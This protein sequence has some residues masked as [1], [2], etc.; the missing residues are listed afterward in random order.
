MNRLITGVMT[1][2]ALI[3]IW[4]A[5]TVLIVDQRTYAI[6]STLGKAQPRLIHTPGLYFKWPFPFA[7][8][9]TLDK[10]MRALNRADVL[11]ARCADQKEMGIQ[12]GIQWRIMEPRLYIRRFGNDLR[13]AELQLSEYADAAA[14]A[15]ISRRSAAQLM[16]EN[17][18]MGRAIRERAMVEARKLGIE[19]TDARVIRLNAHM[20]DTDVSAH[21]EAQY[22]QAANRLRSAGALEAADIRAS[23]QK[24]R[25][26]HLAQ[27]YR[28]AQRLKG[29]GDAQA[30]LIEADVYKRDPQFYR[31]YKK[32]EI[33]R[34][35]FGAHDV[36][37]DS[38]EHE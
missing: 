22:Q 1:L 12:W 29:E 38:L 4:I 7:Q 15:F 19:I 16:A 10:R 27:A 33:Y 14:R 18:P 28:Q 25:E 30:A 20:E 13:R 34:K 2:I 32:L 26:A 21:M 37:I 8:V 9:L 6:V 5:S 17:D 31:F 11:R 24:E 35:S 23:A 36:I 3:L